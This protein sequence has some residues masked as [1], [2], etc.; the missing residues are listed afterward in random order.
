[1]QEFDD[2]THVVEINI[3]ELENKK[4]DIKIADKFNTFN[5]IT[6]SWDEVEKYLDY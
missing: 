5:Y 2:Q 6:D 3:S 4:I 1:M